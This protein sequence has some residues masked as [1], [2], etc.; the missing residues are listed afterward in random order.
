MNFPVSG[1]SDSISSSGKVFGTQGLKASQ[2]SQAARPNGKIVMGR[3]RSSSSSEGSSRPEGEENVSSEGY[4]EDRRGTDLGDRV[5]EQIEEMM[6]EEQ[7]F[8]KPREKHEI[9]AKNITNTPTDPGKPGLKKF[10]GLDLLCSFL[11]N[12]EK[13]EHKEVTKEEHQQLIREQEKELEALEK[14]RDALH[15]EVKESFSETKINLDPEKAK[16]LEN[17]IQL[18]HQKLEQHLIELEK[19]PKNQKPE[20]STAANKLPS[21]SE[22]SEQLSTKSRVATRTKNPEIS[23]KSGAAAQEADKRGQLEDA[24]VKVKQ[25]MQTTKNEINRLSQDLENISPDHSDFSIV[26]TELDNQKKIYEKDKNLLDRGEKYL[27]GELENDI[28]SLKQERQMIKSEI[29]D[30]SK[31][32]NLTFSGEHELKNLEGSYKFS[33]EVLYS[34]EKKLTDHKTDYAARNHINNEKPVQ[35]IT[36]RPAQRISNQPMRVPNARFLKNTE[37][38]SNDVLEKLVKSKKGRLDRLEGEMKKIGNPDHPDYKAKQAEFEKLNAEYQGFSNQIAINNGRNG[39]K[40]EPAAREPV[41]ISAKLITN[42]PPNTKETAVKMDAIKEEIPKLPATETKAENAEPIIEEKKVESTEAVKKTEKAEVVSEEKIN[43]FK[44]KF[45]TTAAEIAFT[46]KQYL[47]DIKLMREVHALLTDPNR[48]KRLRKGMSPEQENEFDKICNYLGE[49]LAVLEQKSQEFI[50]KMEKQGQADEIYNK[51]KIINDK[52]DKDENLSEEAKTDLRNQRTALIKESESI[53]QEIVTAFTEFNN[54]DLINAYANHSQAVNELNQF[55]GKIDGIHAWEKMMDKFI[56]KRDLNTLRTPTG[57][58]IFPVQRITKY[59][60]LSDQLNKISDKPSEFLSQA[61]ANYGVLASPVKQTAA[62]FEKFTRSTNEVTHYLDDTRSALALSENIQNTPSENLRMGGDE[63]NKSSRKSVSLPEFT[64]LKSTQQKLQK[65][66]E[67][68]NKLLE[69]NREKLK[70]INKS[71][72]PQ[73]TKESEIKKIQEE[74]APFVQIKTELENSL[75]KLNES[76]N[77][78]KIDSKKEVLGKEWRVINKVVPSIISLWTETSPLINLNSKQ[79]QEK[80]LFLSSG[81][82]KYEELKQFEGQGQKIIEAS[83]SELIQEKD[84]EKADVP[85]SNKPTE[86]FLNR[87]GEEINSLNELVKDHP[88][89]KENAENLVKAFENKKKFVAA[90][91]SKEG[92]KDLTNDLKKISETIQMIESAA[93]HKMEMHALQASDKERQEKELDQ[94]KTTLEQPA[95]KT[96]LESKGK[97]RKR[98]SSIMSK[99]SSRKYEKESLVVEAGAKL[100]SMIATLSNQNLDPSLKGKAKE[101]AQSMQNDQW[102]KEVL[103]QE[104]SKQLENDLDAVAKAETKPIENVDQPT[105]STKDRLISPPSRSDFQRAILT[106]YR[107]EI[108]EEFAKNKDESVSD[109]QKLFTFITDTFNQKATTLYQKKQLLSMAEQW[110]NDPFINSGDVHVPE[111]KSQIINLAS[112]AAEDGSPMLKAMAHQ[113]LDSLTLAGRVAPKA[114]QAK[115]ISMQATIE[116]IANGK[117]D[118]KEYQAAVQ[119]FAAGIT[120]GNV[121]TLAAVPASELGNASKRAKSPNIAKLSDNF[122]AISYAVET[123]ILAP[124]EAKS[125]NLGNS[126]LTKLEP[127]KTKEWNK[128]S[129][130]VF[131]FFMDVEQELFSSNNLQ[132]A[133]AVNAG[134]NAKSIDRLKEMKKYVPEKTQTMHASFNEKFTF[135]GNFKIMREHEEKLKNE[136][137]TYIPIF[138]IHTTYYD[139]AGQN[140]T[141]VN[142]QINNFKIEVFG[143]IA[144]GVNT[145]Q[146]NTAALISNKA[147]N[148][149]EIAQIESKYQQSKNETIDLTKKALEDN[150]WKLSQYIE[151]SPLPSSGDNASI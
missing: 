26:A 63:K 72:Q 51:I 95:Q 15:A 66:I 14:E 68:Q 20:V 34:L 92:N 118:S 143:K 32:E 65:G 53:S 1:R 78:Q 110:V 48:A 2:K 36:N 124:T 147:S 59:T 42:S 151:P 127:D 133:F 41:H 98:R 132:G 27:I 17:L 57:A 45:V 116:K 85:A 104:G 130:K 136:N 123:F 131:E 67:A 61:G 99:M 149:Q 22:V 107:G 47:A 100:Q 19:S 38:L 11:A 49:N 137:K 7:E 80:N 55:M 82:E 140:E 33:N 24:V 106:S 112:K 83:V 141:I 122:N 119:A 13:A 84:Y 97:E 75:A 96:A 60:G 111:I 50:N 71:N 86:A 76:Q 142:N 145:I 25:K 79:A 108:I 23:L 139:K 3:Q 21:K 148:I 114:E 28:Q 125:K 93:M 150:A 30:L 89:F 81:I 121:S 70:E 134:L 9:H 52:L 105:L 5:E 144:N 102:V 138:A 74:M 4:S 29:D 101:I 87:L 113:L 8:A 88:E 43:E 40:I 117:L 54:D 94:I 129:A 46:E 90:S 35:V 31:K 103:K 91:L 115:P 10:N 62:D 18:R 39:Q 135:N 37:S 58:F 69:P 126:T 120:A 128:Q 146:K 12:P 77:A 109:S 44:T 73:E 16:K 64:A 56:G 6:R